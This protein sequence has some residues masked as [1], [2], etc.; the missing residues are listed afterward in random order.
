MGDNVLPC[1]RAPLSLLSPALQAWLPADDLA[2]FILDAVGPDG[3]G[4]DRADIS[5]GMAGGRRPMHWPYWGRC[6]GMRMVW[7][8]GRADGSSGCASRMWLSG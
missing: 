5:G 6:C 4:E 3:S 7:R 1:D 8:R 2:W